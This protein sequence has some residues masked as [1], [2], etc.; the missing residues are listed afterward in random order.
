M[1]AIIEKRT[2]AVKN[3]EFRVVK[4]EIWSIEATWWDAVKKETEVKD[5]LK[6]I[7]YIKQD[8]QHPP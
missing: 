8:N 3:E 4:R 6:A 7:G 5:E 1:P 2:R